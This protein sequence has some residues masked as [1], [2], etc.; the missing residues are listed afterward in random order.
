VRVGLGI[1][2]IGF[3]QVG[4]AD[5]GGLAAHLRFRSGEHVMLEASIGAM[6]EKVTD[7]VQRNDVPLAFGLYLF[8]WNTRLAPYFVAQGGGN[9]VHQ[10]Y[11]GDRLDQTQAMAAVGG[12]LEL[13]LGEH[14]TIGADLRKQWRWAQSNGGVATSSPGGATSTNGVPAG[15]LAISTGGGAAPAAVSSLTPVTDESGVA[16]TLAATFY[17]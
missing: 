14:F 10:Q 6:G 11:A 15:A 3:N 4:G 1:S 17:F 12:G 13:R 8:P 2:G 9:F 5:V 7:G 16:Y